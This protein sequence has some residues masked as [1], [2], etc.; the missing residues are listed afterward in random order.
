MKRLLFATDLDGTLLRNNEISEVDLEAVKRLSKEGHL[1]AVSTG[2]PY[3]GVEWIL[4]RYGLDPEYLVLANGALILDREG[5]VI[6][7]EVI[8]LHVVR[9]ITSMCQALGFDV[10]F[11]TGF[12]SYSYQYDFS[13]LILDNIPGCRRIDSLEELA[14]EVSLIS[15]AANH[16]VERTE[17]ALRTILD[18]FGDQVA[19]FRNVS[20]IDVVPKETSKGTGIREVMKREGFE[21]DA[22]YA[23]G[24]SLND[25]SMFMEAGHAF[26]FH[27]VED[28]VRS[29]ADA[30]V[31]SVAECINEHIFTT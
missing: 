4:D 26:T 14:E 31:S 18:K 28:V 11:D 6:R 29:G 1:V 8:G 7:H 3:N 16:G 23:I 22:V 21:K 15:A 5:N 25:L 20:Y 12:R 13:Q 2:R 27:G 9:E 17:E 19:A 24:D 10:S 30:S